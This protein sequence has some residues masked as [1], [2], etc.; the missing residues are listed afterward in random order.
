LAAVA[1]YARHSCGSSVTVPF[2]AMLN[3]TRSWDV[4]PEPVGAMESAE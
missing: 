4:L 3:F 2:T 1:G